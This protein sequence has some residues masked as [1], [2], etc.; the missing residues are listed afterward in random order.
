ML[1]PSWRRWRRTRPSCSK[2][3]PRRRRFTKVREILKMRKKPEKT[4]AATGLTIVTWEKLAGNAL[5]RIELI[6]V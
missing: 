6:F 2:S 1:R 4:P 5:E 3:S